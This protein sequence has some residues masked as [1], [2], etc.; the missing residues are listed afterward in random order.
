MRNTTWSCIS[1]DLW[2]PCTELHAPSLGF[3]CTPIF[4]SVNCPISNLT[5]TPHNDCNSCHISIPT[6]RSSI[7]TELLTPCS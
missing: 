3:P 7:S 1:A 2:Q 6:R 5:H 4:P